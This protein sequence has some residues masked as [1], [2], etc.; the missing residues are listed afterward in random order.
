MHPAHA[1]NQELNVFLLT[2]SHLTFADGTCTHKIPH[3]N[4][5]YQFILIY[6]VNIGKMA[7]LNKN[8]GIIGHFLKDRDFIGNIGN[9]G[10][11]EGLH[12]G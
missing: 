1:I 6:R 7:I 8:I 12:L 5:F 4:F 9:I 2:D 11:L 3:L 10:T